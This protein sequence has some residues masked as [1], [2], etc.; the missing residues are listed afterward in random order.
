MNDGIRQNLHREINVL[1]K[2]AAQD[3]RNCLRM[4]EV[5]ETVDKVHLVMEF[6]EGH[7]LHSLIC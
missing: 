3:C 7:S 2:L 5:I 4:Y 1:Q 6:L